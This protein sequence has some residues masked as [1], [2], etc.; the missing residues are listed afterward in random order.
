MKKHYL[1][2]IIC[3]A[4]IE[5]SCQKI[6]FE[7]N[8][9]ETYA[10]TKSY[11]ILAE[12]T[13]L[14]PPLLS[15]LRTVSD[16]VKAD[17]WFSYKDDTIAGSVPPYDPEVEKNKSSYRSTKARGWTTVYFKGRRIFSKDWSPAYM[18]SYNM[19]TWVEYGKCS[20]YQLLYVKQA[21]ANEKLFVSA[22]DRLEEINLLVELECALA[23]YINDTA[24]GE[25]RVSIWQA[26]RENTII[27]HGWDWVR[28]EP[29]FRYYILLDLKTRE[30]KRFAV[31]YYYKN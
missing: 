19:I 11:D 18:S 14:L 17:S 7:K 23:G 31:D 25:Y 27:I 2:L 10:K 12:E 28:V 8:D 29:K 22:G 4:F 21:Y 1:L 3:V 24:D 16:D 5:S 26:E 13:K 20:N 30:Y 6:E 15:D 9:F